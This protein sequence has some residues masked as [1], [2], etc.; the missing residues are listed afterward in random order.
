MFLTVGTSWNGNY[1]TGNIQ[2]IQNQNPDFVVFYCTQ[3][4]NDE[5]MPEIYALNNSLQ[6]KSTVEI[7]R[8][9]NDLEQIKKEIGSSMAQYKKRYESTTVDYT[10]GTK[11]MSAGIIVICNRKNCDYISYITGTKDNQ[12]R[13]K[14]GTEKMNTI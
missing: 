9:E 1:S 8:D 12:G 2:S 7:I 13:V 11:A 4:S 3:K 5:T 14:T 10:S 6:A